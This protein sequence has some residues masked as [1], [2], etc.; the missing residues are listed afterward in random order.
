M[1]LQHLE[2]DWVIGV[3]DVEHRGIAGGGADDEKIR[4][5]RPCGGAAGARGGAA[6]SSGA[7]PE[8]AAAAA[9]PFHQHVVTHLAAKAVGTATSTEHRRG[10]GVT[11]FVIIV[12]VVVIVIVKCIL[13]TV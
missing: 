6:C 9:R 7:H 12:I 5:V 1:S 3:C 13:M 2:E 4:F 8:A 11:L 10:R